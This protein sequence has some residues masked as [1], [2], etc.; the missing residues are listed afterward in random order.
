MAF[1]VLLY[2]QT[3]HLN[4]AQTLDYKLLQQFGSLELLA[5]QIV[6]GFI[7]G[8]HKSP[9]HGFSVEFSEHRLYNKGESTKHIDWKLFARTDRLFVKKYEEETN[10]RCQIILDTSS[11]MYYPEPNRNKMMFSV[12][13]AASIIH[14]LKK[15]RDASGL[16]LFSDTLEEYIPPKSNATHIQ[17]LYSVLEAQLKRPAEEKKTAAADAIHKMAEIL[18]RRS[19][20][21]VFSDMLESSEEHDKLFAAL[22]HLKYNRHEVLLFHTMDKKSELDFEFSNEPRK[23]I[24]METGEVIKAYP[25]DVKEQYT[26][27]ITKFRKDLRLK[28]A[29]YEID[30]IEAD[31]ALGFA[32]ILQPF[33]V[34]RSKMM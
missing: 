17:R 25:A 8:L 2:L 4:T 18:H 22:Q 30:L 3:A 12:Y 6:E 10:L 14:L 31:I 11:S 33:L 21:I 26:N 19:L 29:Q 20:V 9:F 13:A 1:F 16:T 7:V 24:D 15:Q 5:R 28:C 27:Y 32:Q 23:F 34:R